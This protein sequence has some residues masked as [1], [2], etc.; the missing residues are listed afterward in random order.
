M[1]L[2][3]SGEFVARI[4]FFTPLP[5]YFALPL[6]KAPESQKKASV[7]TFRINS[8]LHATCAKAS[9]RLASANWI[10]TSPQRTD[11]QGM[12]TRLPSD[13][14]TRGPK[15]LSS[16]RFHKLT[17]HLSAYVLKHSTR[18][19]KSVACVAIAQP[20]RL[21]TVANPSPKRR[22]PVRKASPKR[23][24]P[25]SMRRRSGHPTS[26]HARL[27]SGAPTT[28]ALRVSPLHFPQDLTYFRRLY[29]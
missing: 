28:N 25:G 13:R 22:Q 16:L 8:I 3:G 10:L 21:P 17:H 20:Q 2:A 29:L 5:A 6:V 11:S 1:R 18:S 19:K 15:G 12:C 14:T 4:K 24:H 23:R 9:F 27:K 26:L 7:D